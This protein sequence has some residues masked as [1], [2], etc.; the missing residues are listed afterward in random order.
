[1]RRLREAREQEAA[2]ERARRENVLRR[3]QRAG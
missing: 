3:L 2:E 1:L